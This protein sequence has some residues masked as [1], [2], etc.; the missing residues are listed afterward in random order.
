MEALEHHH[1]RDFD[2]LTLTTRSCGVTLINSS[3][4]SGHLLGEVAQCEG[5]SLSGEHSEDE[6][7]FLMDA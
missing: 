1:V 7:L 6:P 3:N 2:L 5:S 4:P